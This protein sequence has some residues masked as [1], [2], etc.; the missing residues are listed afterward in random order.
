MKKTKT[1]IAKILSFESNETELRNQLSSETMDWDWFVK[2]SSQLGV[3]TTAYCRLNQKGLLDLVPKDLNTYLNEITKINRH[4]NESLLHQVKELSKLF[5]D[6]KINHVFVKGCALLACGCYT[7]FGER[8]IG[9][10]DVLVEPTN[11][12]KAEQLL[13]D[14]NY[15]SS[16]PSLFGKYKKHRHLPR[17]VHPDR[18][19]AVEIHSKLLRKNISKTLNPHEII[20]NRTMVT[21]VYVPKLEENIE[22]LILNH[23]INDFGYLFKY[24]NFKTCYDSLVL[25]HKMNQI[26]N[27]YNN[28]KYHRLFFTLRDSY[29]EPLQKDSKNKN[30]SV[31]KHFYKHINKNGIVGQIYTRLVT[32]YVGLIT[33]L[34]GLKLFVKNKDFRADI[35]SHKSDVLKLLKG[36]NK[37]IHSK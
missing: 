2:S 9:D 18:L 17:L 13:L 10:I 37:E 32:V 27:T 21:Q 12:Y 8:L 4:R 20:K 7:D 24:I 5:S 11:L 15:A 29:F 25:E 6:H 30:I 33:C 28:S 16:V 23:Q 22:I 36:Q 34:I 26:E 1:S 14:L 35:W 31:V 3:M 19:G